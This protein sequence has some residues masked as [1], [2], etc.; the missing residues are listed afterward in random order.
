LT[1]PLVGGSGLPVRAALDFQLCDQPKST[2]LPGQVDTFIGLE[3][4][5]TVRVTIRAFDQ[6]VL[7]HVTASAQAIAPV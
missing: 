6:S 3:A 4:H 5:L 7:L 2:D 1:L